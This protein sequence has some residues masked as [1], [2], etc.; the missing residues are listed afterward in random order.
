MLS[1][2]SSDSS[3][4]W[5]LLTIFHSLIYRLNLPTSSNY[6]ATF[7]LTSVMA[8]KALKRIALTL[9]TH[10]MAAQAN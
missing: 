5:P 1:Y 2:T 9:L 3:P 10:I 8:V 6:I 7:P 4:L